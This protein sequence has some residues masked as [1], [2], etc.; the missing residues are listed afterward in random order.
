MHKELNR[1]KPRLTN[2]KYH[3]MKQRRSSELTSLEVLIPPY[4]TIRLNWIALDASY[5]SLT[6]AL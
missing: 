1:K 2:T 6:G 3:K 4:A 5:S